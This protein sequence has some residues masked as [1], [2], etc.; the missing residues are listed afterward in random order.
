M[1]SPNHDYC[2]DENIILLH[3]DGII[4]STN[5]DRSS[6][7]LDFSLLLKIDGSLFTFI[8]RVLRKVRYRSC[9]LVVYYYE[10]SHSVPGRQSLSRF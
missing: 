8:S 7:P 2:N 4:T 6:S 1:L 3:F 5:Y 10:D 9:F